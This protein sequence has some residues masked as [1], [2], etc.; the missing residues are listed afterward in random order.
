[1]TAT[2]TSRSVS[3][4]RPWVV[5]GVGGSKRSRGLQAA[6]AGLGLAPARLV[7]WRDWL[8]QPDCLAALLAEPCHV[9]IEPPGDDAQ[10][11][12]QLLHAGC[13]ALGRPRCAAP[14]HGELLATDAWYAGFE[15][16]MARLAAQL[17]GTPARPVNAPADIL[18]MTDKLACQRRLQAHGVP[19]ADLLG[20]VDGY[21]ALRALLD[22]RGLDRVFLK[23][24]YG[25]SAAGVLAYRRNR[26][27]DEQATTSAALVPSGRG[28]RLFNVKRLRSY[29]RAAEVR[30]VVDGIAAQQAYAEAW[31]PKPRCGAGHFDLRVLALDGRAAHRV[32]RIGERAMTNLHLDSR[33][34]D[35]DAL[36][37]VEAQRRLEATAEQAAG[38]FRASRLVGLDIVVHRGQAH[39]LEANA[40]G[41]LLPG[42]LWQGQDTHAALQAAS[43]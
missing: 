1:M 35:V 6:R 5:L 40:F 25:S 23:A 41:D 10:V 9:K 18:A 29:Q 8:A 19:T 2:A 14:E 12:L 11:H 36:L 21:D 15:Q 28:P 38:A 31:L 20:P 3:S 22:A 37:T 7:E 13:D 27:G 30:Q 17:A 43:A 42:L 26:R 39:V 33:R 32:A 34:G 16:A 4:G 24:R